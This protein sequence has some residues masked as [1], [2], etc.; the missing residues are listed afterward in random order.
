MILINTFYFFTSEGETLIF[1][2][3]LKKMLLK[4]YYDSIWQML[5]AI[6]IVLLNPNSIFKE[7]NYYFFLLRKKFSIIENNLKGNHGVIPINT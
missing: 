7:N 3:K 5:I 4:N 1:I 6:N 2:Y